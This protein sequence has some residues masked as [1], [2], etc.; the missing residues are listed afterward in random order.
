MR[1]V[2]YFRVCSCVGWCGYTPK[3][4]QNHFRLTCSSCINVTSTSRRLVQ[5]GRTD[6]LPRRVTCKDRAT[7]SAG[8]A[9]DAGWGTYPDGVPKYV[10]F[11]D[12][13]SIYD[14]STGALIACVACGKCL[15]SCFFCATRPICRIGHFTLV[16]CSLASFPCTTLR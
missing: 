8:G 7:Y 2:F 3:R 16:M 13:I 14:T 4:V 11:Q 6:A 12:V 1:H 5:S 9:Y 15:L 10:V